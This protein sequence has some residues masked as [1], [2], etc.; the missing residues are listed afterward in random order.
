MKLSDGP[1]IPP[2]IQL[3]LT[4]FRPLETLEEYQKRYGDIFLSKLIGLGQFVV[5][6]H[7]QAI[8]EIMAADPKV[9]KSGSANQLLHPLVGDDSML[10]LDSDRHQSQRRLLNPAFHGERMRAYGKLICEITEQV[11]SDW[12]VGKSF[13]ARPTMQKISLRVILKA[14]FGIDEGERFEELQR[15][16]SGMLDT[17]DSPLKS[18]F[19]FVKALQK[20]LGAWSPWGQFVRKREQ[21]NKLIYAEIQERRQQPHL[22][23]EDILSLMMSARD[24]A[25]QPMT[26][27][28]LRDEL[29]TLLFAGHETTAS[30]LAWALYW[31]HKLPTV[32]D[33]LLRELESIGED[34]DASEI[35]RLPYLTAVCQ[36]TL[37]IYPIALFT[38]SRILQAPFQVMGYDFEAGTRFSPCIYLIHHRE[39]IY[40]EPKQFKPERFLERQFSPYEYL[41][42]GGGNRRCLGMAFAMYEMKLVLATILS[43]WQLSLADNHPVCPVRRGVTTTPAGGVRMV[44]TAKVSQYPKVR[45]EAIAQ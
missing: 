33:K 20:D 43:R 4:L 41:P 45:S 39:D 10:L 25:G 8:Q 40:P 22:N 38:F 35:T 36:E 24:E 21:V 44:V 28:E 27:R 31:I 2:L 42:F 1:N 16:L 30:A 7:P 9:F 18:S 32:R 17:F 29:M 15:F 14:V 11:T 3:S 37:R 34:K 23:G 13:I 5:L 12:T 26:D 6:S 19:L